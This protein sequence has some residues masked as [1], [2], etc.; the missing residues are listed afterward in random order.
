MVEEMCDF[1]IKIPSMI[2]N[3]T[4][5]L[6]GISVGWLRL[7]ININLTITKSLGRPHFHSIAILLNASCD[8]LA[9]GLQFMGD[10]EL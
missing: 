3:Y 6:Y 8:P 4:Q 10:S 1:F 2:N 7:D 5:N 9:A